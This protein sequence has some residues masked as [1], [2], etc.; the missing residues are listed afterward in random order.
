MIRLAAPGD[1]RETIQHLLPTASS[2]TWRT[3]SEADRIYVKGTA[4]RSST[5]LGNMIPLGLLLF[6]VAS[7]AMPSEPVSPA[8]SSSPIPAELDGFDWGD[9]VKQGAF[10]TY[11]RLRESLVNNT[12]TPE[13]I[14]GFRAIVGESGRLSRI[15]TL[16]E[17]LKGTDRADVVTQL[18]AAFLRAESSANVLHD[19]LQ[20]CIDRGMKEADTHPRSRAGYYA[21]SISYATY[22]CIKAYERTGQVRFLE[23]VASTFERILPYRDSQLHRVDELRGRTMHGWGSNTYHKGYYTTNVTAA[24]RITYP[25]AC[26]CRIVYNSPLLQ[27]RFGERARRFLPIIEQVISDYDR[28]YYTVKGTDQGYYIGY[29]PVGER[30]KGSKPRFGVEPLNHMLSAGNT[31]IILHDITGKPEYLNRARAL[32]AYFKASMWIEENGCVVWSY[33]PTPRRRRHPS[34]EFIWKAQ[35]TVHFALLAASHGIVFTEEDMRKICNTFMTNVYRESGSYNATIYQNFTPLDTFK[36]KTRGG[37]VNMLPFI[38]LDQYCP[39]IRQVLEEM[40]SRRPGVGG[41]FAR[42]NGAIAYAHRL[43]PTAVRKPEK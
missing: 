3:P 1:R 13:S 8:A 24:G 26:F 41:W 33:A 9:I 40:I 17:N 6:G 38:Q 37:Y 34:P 19:Y 23:L 2:E 30:K 42:S 27:E 28:E 35:V 10:L 14:I 39:S 29:R 12:I 11:D 7:T 16:L 43:T 31:L 21:W 36:G 4:M 18:Y 22:A 15:R 25:V 32:A 5:R 20:L